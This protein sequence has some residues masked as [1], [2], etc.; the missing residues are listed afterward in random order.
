[1]SDTDEI[2][3]LIRGN[4]IVDRG[5]SSGVLRVNAVVK[6]Y[7]SSETSARDREIAAY[8]RLTAK[9]RNPSSYIVE[10]YGVLDGSPLLRFQPNGS[11]RKY[12]AVRDE[13]LDVQP[14]LHWAEQICMGLQ[15]VHD[16]G[17]V[18]G[19]LSC[20]D[21]YLDSK[22]NAKVGGFARSS[23]HDPEALKTY[24]ADLDPTPSQGDLFALGS[25]LFEVMTGRTPF[26]VEEASE[27]ES[28]LDQ[29]HTPWMGDTL[30][31]GEIILECWHGINTSAN[32]ALRDITFYKNMY[33]KVLASP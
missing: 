25:T 13:P 33:R 10:F 17:V 22:L 2:P 19:N 20:R 3:D 24:D 5:P 30:F 21:I 15:F 11:I 26:N 8:Q 18:H 28:R 12:R 16:Q 6:C 9:G 31:L 4:D 7:S 23:I 14:R 29:G 1:M 32:D 27:V